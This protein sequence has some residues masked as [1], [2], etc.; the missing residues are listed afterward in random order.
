MFLF[1]NSF[2]YLKTYNIN[3]N[4]IYSLPSSKKLYKFIKILIKSFPEYNIDFIINS[5]INSDLYSNHREKKFEIFKYLS[6][7]EHS[8]PK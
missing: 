1:I 4:L 8:V 6:L 5:V 3:N 2:N 7:L